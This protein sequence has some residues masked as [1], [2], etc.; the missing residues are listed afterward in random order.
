M[1]EQLNGNKFNIIIN[2]Q[3]KIIMLNFAE[4]LEYF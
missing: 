2:A 3:C 4:I 1:D